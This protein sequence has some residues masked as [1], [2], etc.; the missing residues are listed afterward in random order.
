MRALARELVARGMAS[1]ISYETVRRVLK[2]ELTSWR[3][4]PRCYPPVP[5]EADFVIRR[6]AVRDRYSRP[7]DA[8]YPEICRDEHAQ[9][10]RAD[11][12]PSH[13]AR[14]GHPATYDYEYVRCGTCTIWMFVEPLGQW[15]M[16]RVTARRTAADWAR[17]V[18]ALVD[19]PRYRE[20]EC[21]ILVCDNLN[22]HAYASFFPGLSARRGGALGSARPA[23][24]YA[25]AQQLA[26]H[27]GTG[28]ERPDAPD[29]VPAHAHAGRGSRA[30]HRLGG[31]PQRGQKGIDWQ[32]RT[33]DARVCLKHLYHSIET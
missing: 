3:R 14:P 7:Y 17:Q 18:K 5:P 15:R 25:P 21:L 24:V 13:P 26:Q 10:L 23:G 32:F 2:K 29:P 28:T 31:G 4:V 19:H 30:G 9:F 16:A 22:A 33:A 12:W 27:G 8:R 11:K 1:R 6:E 20:T